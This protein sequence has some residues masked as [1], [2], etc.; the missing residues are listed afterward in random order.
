MLHTC[1]HALTV[2]L[3]QN[4]YDDSTVLT[5]EGHLAL[6]MHAGHARLASSFV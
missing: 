4:K 2:V 5:E 6:G 3:E 1:T